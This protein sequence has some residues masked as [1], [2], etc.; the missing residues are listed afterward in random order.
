MSTC[1]SKFTANLHFSRRSESSKLSVFGS[2]ILCF[3]ISPSILSFWY[4]KYA[5]HLLLSIIVYKYT[6]FLL[7]DL[8]AKL[9]TRISQTFLMLRFRDCSYCAIWLFSRHQIEHLAHAHV[10]HWHTRALCGVKC[11][12][13]K[14][15]RI[16]C[17]HSIKRR[18]CMNL[19]SHLLS[20]FVFL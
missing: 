16:E 10:L 11:I 14:K 5:G 6:I 1:H 20:N 4:L 12:V 7:W 2:I 15:F 8:H 18:N 3:S 13:E 17:I 19:S 9:I